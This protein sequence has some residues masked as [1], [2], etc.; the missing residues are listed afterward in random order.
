MRDFEQA[1]DISSAQ[2]N[3][4]SDNMV[5]GILWKFTIPDVLPEHQNIHRKWSLPRKSL[6]TLG[7]NPVTRE[8]ED[9][10]MQVL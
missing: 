2:A 4:L 1:V 6:P 7:L 3:D 8:V 10:E 5:S 9:G